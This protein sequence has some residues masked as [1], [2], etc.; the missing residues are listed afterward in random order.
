[1]S[2]KISTET[3]ITCVLETLQNVSGITH[4]ECEN[5][6]NLNWNK[7]TNELKVCGFQGEGSY[8]IIKRCPF[9]MLKNMTFYP[10]NN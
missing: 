6:Y 5:Y 7:D 1:M 9:L 10:K 8:E 4:W 2:V 3:N